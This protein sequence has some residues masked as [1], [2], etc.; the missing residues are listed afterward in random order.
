MSSNSQNHFNEGEEEKEKTVKYF[1]M[2]DVNPDR[3]LSGIFNLILRQETERG[4]IHKSRWFGDEDLYN[5]LKIHFP[6]DK[7]GL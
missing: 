1:L 5:L 3:F 6:E 2:L 4:A 7:E